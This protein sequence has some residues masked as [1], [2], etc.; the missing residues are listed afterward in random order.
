MC[1]CVCVR[2]RV[3]ERAGNIF[4]ESKKERHRDQTIF[5]SRRAHSELPVIIVVPAFHNPS[6]NRFLRWASGHYPY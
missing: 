5:V 6:E 4:H 1:V 3:S 2:A